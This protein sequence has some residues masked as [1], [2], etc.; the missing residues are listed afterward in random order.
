MF[1]SVIRRDTHN[2]RFHNPA[3]VMSCGCTPVP[4]LEPYETAAAQVHYVCC[5]C[6]VGANRVS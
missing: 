6:N 3:C 4:R 5:L 2:E 1:E